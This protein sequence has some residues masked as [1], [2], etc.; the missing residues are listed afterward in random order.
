[1]TSA[2]VMKISTNGQISI[3]AAVRARWGAERVVAVDLG[4][5]VVIRP[6]GPDPIGGLRAKYRGRGPT[7]ARARADQRR[8]DVD[9]GASP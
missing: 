2:Y 1:M 3:P 5:R 4:D 9:R 7:T 6:I 8:E